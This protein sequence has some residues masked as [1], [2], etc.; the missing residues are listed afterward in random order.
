MPMLPILFKALVYIDQ[1]LKISFYFNVN[2]IVICY[3]NPNIE[4]RP[5]LESTWALCLLMFKVVKC[6]FLFTLAYSV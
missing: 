4:Y 5:Y 3:A 6:V 2:T 1:W